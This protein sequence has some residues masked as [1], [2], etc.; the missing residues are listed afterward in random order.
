MWKES[1]TSAIA[2]PLVPRVPEHCLVFLAVNIPV[3]S[4]QA[5]KRGAGIYLTRFL[6]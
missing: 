5:T 3:Y 6:N 1:S 4:K 2:V